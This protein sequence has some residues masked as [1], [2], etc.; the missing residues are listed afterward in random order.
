LA[1]IASGYISIVFSEPNSA[2]SVEISS[3]IDESG[4]FAY[5]GPVDVS[6]ADSGVECGFSSPKKKT[7]GK[8]RGKKKA[9]RRRAH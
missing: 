2:A 8:K 6:D 4:L 5:G 9:A 7:A 3:G 1:N